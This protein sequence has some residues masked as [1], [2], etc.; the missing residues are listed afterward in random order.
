MIATIRRRIR[1][2]AYREVVAWMRANAYGTMASRVARQF[3][4]E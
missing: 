2:A 1:R 4:V 3:E